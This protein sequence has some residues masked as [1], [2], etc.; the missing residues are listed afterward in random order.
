MIVIPSGV[1]RVSMIR[2]TVAVKVVLAPPPLTAPA[3]AVETASINRAANVF[4]LQSSQSSWSWSQSQS[5]NGGNGLNVSVGG[6]GG[7]PGR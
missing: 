1:P 7:G 2:R 5:R 6:G 4:R 3:C